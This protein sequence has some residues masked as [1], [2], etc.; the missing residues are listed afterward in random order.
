[1]QLI[2]YKLPQVRN[3]ERF[4]VIF[5]VNILLSSEYSK[6]LSPSL[7]VGKPAYEYVE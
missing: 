6:I 7:T 2:L 3:I 5:E 4:F 1:M